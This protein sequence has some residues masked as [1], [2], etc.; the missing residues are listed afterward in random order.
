MPLLTLNSSNFLLLWCQ[1]CTSTTIF[2][3][4]SQKYIFL[5]QTQIWYCITTLCH[6]NIDHAMPRNLPP[7]TFWRDELDFESFTNTFGHD[8]E[9]GHVSCFMLLFY[10]NPKMRCNPGAICTQPLVTNIV[11]IWPTAKCTTTCQQT[12]PKTDVI[13]WIGDVT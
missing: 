2:F 8:T 5:K 1:F 6:L 4:S 7:Q 12:V 9:R 10:F 13:E 3:I 11:A